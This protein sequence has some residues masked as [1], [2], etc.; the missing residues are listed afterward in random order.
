MARRVT[1]VACMFGGMIRAMPYSIKQNDSR[2]PAGKKWSVV[3]SDTGDLKG[4]HPDEDSARK[5]QKALYANVPDA[6]RA[7]AGDDCCRE[8]IMYTTPTTMVW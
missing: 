2:C 6:D 5:Q 4:C 7:A 1:S 8:P 3:N